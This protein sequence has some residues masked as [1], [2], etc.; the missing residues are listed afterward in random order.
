MGKRIV[1]WG[2]AGVVVACAVAAAALFWF[3]GFSPD[4]AAFPI[5][6]IDVSHHQGKIDWR[7]VAADDVAFAIIKATEGG[8]HVDT[9]FATNLREARAAGLAVGAYHFFTFCRPGADQAKNFISAVPPGEPL[10]PPVVDIEFGGNCP[11]RPSPQ[12][13]NAEL[14]AFLGPVETAFGKQAIFYLTDEAADAYSGGIIARQRWLRSLAI[15]PG[16]NDW[17]Y[18]QYHNMGLVDGIKGDVD[19][20]VMNG[21]REAGRVVRADALNRLVL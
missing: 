20:N 11:Q 14:A 1:F 6:G 18:W 4:R 8:T 12:Q 16:G 17:I 10:L 21:S 13:L 5:R 3:R 2:L 9:Q 19:L 7:R 15:R